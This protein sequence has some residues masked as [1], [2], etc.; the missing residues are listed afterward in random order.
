MIFLFSAAKIKNLENKILKIFILS[1]FLPCN[2]AATYSFRFILKF[3]NSIARLDQK[4]LVRLFPIIQPRRA[5]NRPVNFGIC[6]EQYLSHFLHVFENVRQKRESKTRKERFHGCCIIGHEPGAENEKSFDAAEF[7]CLN[8][9]GNC[10]FVA[11]SYSSARA[12]RILNKKL[13]FK[14]I[15]LFI[16]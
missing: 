2:V 5:A 11:I 12:E 4:L 3:F 8:Y 9:F 10:F 13:V 1:R 7:G 6:S 16:F 15:F 14:F